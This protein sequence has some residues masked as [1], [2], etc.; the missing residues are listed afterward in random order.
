[1]CRSTDYPLNSQDHHNTLKLECCKVELPSSFSISEMEL[2]VVL[3]GHVPTRERVATPS[4]R[5]NKHKVMKLEAIPEE[6]ELV[7][8]KGD[9]NSELEEACIHL[10]MDLEVLRRAFD[11]GIWVLFLGL[12]YMVSR[13]SITKKFR[14]SPTFS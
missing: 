4:T 12:G 8:T 2:K 14:P 3:D 10:E 11:M 5:N 13:A 1:M 9:A 6:T 7:H